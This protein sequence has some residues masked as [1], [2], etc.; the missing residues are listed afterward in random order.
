MLH[1]QASLCHSQCKNHH[2]HSKMLVII[3][4]FY[5]LYST[6]IRKYL[7]KL[8]YLLAY[9]AR[10]EDL[11]CKKNRL[12]NYIHGLY[13][14]CVTQSV[15]RFVLCI[16]PYFLKSYK[17]L[18]SFLQIKKIHLENNYKQKVPKPGFSPDLSVLNA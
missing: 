7:Q 2:Y 5:I 3:F 8:F 12:M 1:T 15:T 13:M 11:I 16:A 18:L 10:N 14:L 9:F 17:R 4:I 6:I